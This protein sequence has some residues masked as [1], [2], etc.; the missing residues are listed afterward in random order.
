MIK[1]KI[2]DMLFPGIVINLIIFVGFYDYYKYPVK[3]YILL[4]Y[5]YSKNSYSFY[6][7]EIFRENILFIFIGLLFI[8][9]FVLKSFIKDRINR[10]AITDYSHIEDIKSMA[11]IIYN[12][13]AK[14]RTD[15]FNKTKL[16]IIISGLSQL[17]RLYFQKPLMNIDYEVNNTIRV[18][19][20]NELTHSEKQLVRVAALCY[21]VVVDSLIFNKP[22]KSVIPVI[23]DI[24]QLLLIEN[25]LDES[26]LNNL[27]FILSKGF[28]DIER[29]GLAMVFY[30]KLLKFEDENY[31]FKNMNPLLVYV[32]I[33]YGVLLTNLG[34]HRIYKYY[35]EK[36]ITIQKSNKNLGNGIYFEILVDLFTVYCHFGNKEEAFKCFDEIAMLLKLSKIRKYLK[37][38]GRNMQVTFSKIGS[39][40][41][42][43]GE[44]LD[45]NDNLLLGK[46]LEKISGKNFMQDKKISKVEIFNEVVNNLEYQKEIHKK[47]KSYY[48]EAYYLN[49]L[50][51]IYLAA[52][53]GLRNYSLSLKYYM[54]SIKVAKEGNV[55]SRLIRNYSDIANY[56]LYLIYMSEGIDSIK[57]RNYLEKAGENVSEAIETI[58]KSMREATEVFDWCLDSSTLFEGYAYVFHLYIEILVEQGQLWSALNCLEQA[59]TRTLLKLDGL[60]EDFY[61]NNELIKLSGDYR[62]LDN[63]EE[64]EDIE[65]IK[66]YQ[67]F[68]NLSEKYNKN[69]EIAEPKDYVK[70][71]LDKLHYTFDE[72]TVIIEFMITEFAHCYIFIISKA[73][74]NLEAEEVKMGNLNLYTK[75]LKGVT[76]IENDP[77]YSYLRIKKIFDSWNENFKEFKEEQEKLGSQPNREKDIEELDNNLNKHIEELL[78][79]LKEELE[80]NTVLD[81]L[82]ENIENIVFIPHNLLNIFPLHCLR[83]NDVE[84]SEYLIDKYNIAYFPSLSLYVSTA[85]REKQR[86]Y[87]EHETFVGIDSLMDEKNQE[88][89]SILQVIPDNVHKIA[90]LKKDERIV[91]NIVAHVSNSTYLHF[92][93]HGLFDVETPVASYLV[94]SKETIM[95]ETKFNEILTLN[96]DIAEDL[97]ALSNNE[98]SNIYIDIECNLAKKLRVSED[99]KHELDRYTFKGKLYAGEVFTRFS[100]PA[101]KLVFLSA[102]ESGMLHT[103]IADENINLTAAFVQSGANNVISTLWLAHN[104]ACIRFSEV[105][106]KNL[107]TEKKSP[108]IEV[109]TES[110]RTLKN[111]HYEKISIWGTFSF[112]GTF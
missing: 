102:C 67:R 66:L 71:L 56:Y 27:F 93:C 5:N 34:Q 20:K 96:P 106:Y 40:C 59:K 47:N 57:K 14:I 8:I 75:R 25:F 52:A 35:C 41:S 23:K 53:P 94:L 69:I 22:V 31:M 21:I 111:Q 85:I 76:N 45:E 13:Y 32:F 2:Y 48:G 109:F 86:D 9:S 108:M 30:D 107:F 33:N 3:Y 26:E 4:I 79:M 38:K 63:T 110:I 42:L 73:R 17:A 55:K 105:F 49:K 112:I 77:K 39:Y 83:T 81:A 74:L 6:V 51:A 19:E 82:V 18:I 44:K 24:Q 70:N 12:E 11:N 10:S 64:Y 90:L 16:R 36:M 99:I 100:L 37:K 80:F 97:R 43:L 72:N 54:E 50:G 87:A 101:C 15:T 65:F 62:N 29:Y 68:I 61:A 95:P 91:E 103:S 7:P 89:E 84:K 60:S 104:E 28:T 58:F 88:V 46:K 92:T 98:N 1:Y 78:A